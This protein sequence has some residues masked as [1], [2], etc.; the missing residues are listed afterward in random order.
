[1]GGNP[2]K[3]TPLYFTKPNDAIVDCSLTKTVHYPIHTQKLHWEGELVVAIDKEGLRVSPE[4]ALNLVYGYAVGVDL[5]ARD[6]QDEAKKRGRPWDMAK[7]FDQS[8]PIGP[9]TPGANWLHKDR[10]LELW[11]NGEI[12][13]KTTLG[14]M[15]WTV[16]QIISSLSHHVKLQPGDV[17]FTGTPA[18]VGEVKVGDKISARCDGLTNCE[19]EM[20]YSE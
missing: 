19:F 14:S 5:T 18:G 6:L 7:G 10:L 2:Q 4:T 13:Q 20:T 8:A 15:I 12:K 16:P 11:V 1:M 17:I 3:D 9:I